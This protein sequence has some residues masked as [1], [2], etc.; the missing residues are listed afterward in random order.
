M[1]NVVSAA[2]LSSFKSGLMIS[3]AEVALSKATQVVE[4]SVGGLKVICT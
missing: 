2:Y 3:K 4:M 1:T